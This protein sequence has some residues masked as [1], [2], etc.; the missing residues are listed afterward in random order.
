MQAQRGDAGE[1][2]VGFVDQDHGL[3]RALQNALD[4]RQ[5]SRPVPVGLLGLAISTARVAGVM[6]SSTAASGKSSIGTF[7]IDFANRG[8]GDFGIEAVH[9]VG[10]PQQQHFVAVIDVGVDEDLNGFVGAV[11]EDELVRRDAEEIGDR[12]FG[13]AVF[14]IDGE[15]GRAS[16]R[17]FRNS[18]TRGE[19]PTVFSLKSRR[20]F[21]ARPAVG[22]E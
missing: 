15:G 5:A 2:E 13:F 22:G 21:P 6:A 3:A 18:M 17:C 16:R 11:G 10:G 19:Q 8:A 4:G 14:G 1:F 20:S 7:V 9:G 12:G